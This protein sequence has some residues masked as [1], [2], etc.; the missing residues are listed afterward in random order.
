MIRS[1]GNFELKASF[2]AGW[3]RAF[4][5][6]SG[7]NHELRLSQRTSVP[8]TTRCSMVLA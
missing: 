8:W 4:I 2:T 5:V 7:K 6:L 3:L 1:L